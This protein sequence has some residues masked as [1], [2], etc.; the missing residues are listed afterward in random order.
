MDQ[1]LKP[2]RTFSQKQQAFHQHP[3][4]I[5]GFLQEV[6]EGANRRTSQVKNKM[7]VMYL[8]FYYYYYQLLTV[9]RSIQCLLN[10]N[11]KVSCFFPFSLHI[12]N[13][14][15]FYSSSRFTVLSINSQFIY[16]AEL[17]VSSGCIR[18]KRLISQSLLFIAL[19]V[20]DILLNFP[21]HSLFWI[22][23]FKLFLLQTHFFP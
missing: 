5:R 16:I 23:L 21:L 19:F 14:Y 15:S 4:P 20:L 2:R 9:C 12:F 11:Y 18:W 3:G 10:S 6:S 7:K 17:I 13:F 1:T 22:S 8:H